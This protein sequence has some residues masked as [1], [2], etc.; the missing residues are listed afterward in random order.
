MNWLE[1]LFSSC[2]EGTLN[3]RRRELASRL[4]GVLSEILD[5]ST[6]LPQS[7]IVRSIFYAASR[8]D[9]AGPKVSIFIFSD[10]LENSSL[11]G[12]STFLATK[13]TALLNLV[14]ASKLVPR[15]PGGVVRIF[16]VGRSYSAAR[17]DLSPSQMRALD[18]FWRSYF[19]AAGATEI[20][21]SPRLKF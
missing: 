7:D 8:V 9:G 17:P 3:Q 2:T 11:I 18:F 13:G 5:R 19:Q 14:K 20:E 21:I 6:E 15:L 4:R 12:G 16:G 10:M 1:K